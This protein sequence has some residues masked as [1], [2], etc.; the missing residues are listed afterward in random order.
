ML[1]ASLRAEAELIEN[2]RME[3][4]QML[5][6]IRQQW[7]FFENSVK[8]QEQMLEDFQQ[9]EI[10]VLQLG[11]EERD[12]S[13]SSHIEYESRIFVDA[14]ACALDRQ[15]ILQTEN[16]VSPLNVTAEESPKRHGMN[17]ASKDAT[18]ELMSASSSQQTRRTAAR[19]SSEHSHSK[20]VALSTYASRGSRQSFQASRL[21]LENRLP[22]STEV[23][24]EAEPTRTCIE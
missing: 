14:R 10:E 5:A 23:S 17:T 7:E 21:N 3:R 8:D 18:N 12:R 16:L 22:S 9:K 24:S 4:T 1:D 15:R 13:I 6:H 19:S 11:K 20:E 2:M